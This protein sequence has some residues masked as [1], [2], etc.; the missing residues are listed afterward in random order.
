MTMELYPEHFEIGPGLGF[1]V[2]E[3]NRPVL[4][5]AGEIDRFEMA[6]RVYLTVAPILGVDELE[7]RMREDLG[8]SEGRALSLALRVEWRSIRQNGEASIIGPVGMGAPV[9]VCSLDGLVETEE[10]VGA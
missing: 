5:A 3:E 7:K 4:I 1:Y 2:D 6:D 9:T 10:I 8:Q